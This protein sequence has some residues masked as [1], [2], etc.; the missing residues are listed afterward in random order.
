MKFFTTRF[1][2]ATERC[3]AFRRRLIALVAWALVAPCAYADRLASPLELIYQP[4]NSLITGKLIE[5]NPAGRLVFVRGQVLSGEDHPPE[6][7][8]VRVSASLLSQ[9]KLNQDYILAYT[10]YISSPMQ[11]EKMI[12]NPDGP[13]LLV[14]N[15]L[16]PALFR[17]TAPIRALLRLGSSEHGRES[18]RTLDALL[19]ALGGADPA[20]QNLAAAEI[21]LNEDLRARIRATDRGRVET[22]VRNAEAPPA[23]RT[24]LL[25]LAAREPARF[26]EGW[27]LDVAQGLVAGMPLDGY[28]AASDGR[29]GLVRSA[30]GLLDRR[31][32]KLPSSALIRWVRSDSSAIAEVALLM[33]RR[34]APEQ[35]RPAIEAALADPHLPTEM[36]AFL[37]DHLRRLD[38]LEERLRAQREG[39]R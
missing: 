35:E 6:R 24:T 31:S 30:L 23:A 25:E 39:S 38:L 12:R 11:A 37:S 28:A 33:L 13:R 14:S 15:G 9:V 16:E 34:Q 1:A 20:L 4:T 19:D 17:D 21:A 18:R 26:G 36:R 29:G 10:A 27:W 32:V 22:F 5:I 3:H 7:I 2:P 8:D